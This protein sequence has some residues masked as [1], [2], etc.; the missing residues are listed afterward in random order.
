[1]RSERVEH[2][3]CLYRSDV[4]LIVKYSHP[5]ARIAPFCELASCGELSANPLDNLEFTLNSES[6]TAQSSILHEYLHHTDSPVTRC[7]DPQ[8]SHGHRH[9]FTT[10]AAVVALST[11]FTRS[12]SVHHHDVPTHPARAQEPAPRS[13]RVHCAY[14]ATLRR[15][16]REPIADCAQKRFSSRD[17]ASVKQN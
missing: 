12:P 3:R 1:M 16:H 7:A 17:V 11:S 2:V 10:R 6:I 15:L 4:L 13:H 8:A 14:V 5:S 9:S